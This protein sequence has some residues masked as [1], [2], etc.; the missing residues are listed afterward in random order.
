MAATL[1][2]VP[3][4]P[5]FSASATLQSCLKPVPSDGAARTRL[6]VS[7]FPRAGAEGA[8]DP[9][10]VPCASAYG[11]WNLGLAAAR[12]NAFGVGVSGVW[13]DC[14]TMGEMRSLLFLSVGMPG[15]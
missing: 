11:V 3:G 7:T 9:E 14:L 2:T 5:S 13:Y 6:R 8:S 1:S 15:P 12:V 4:L 10:V